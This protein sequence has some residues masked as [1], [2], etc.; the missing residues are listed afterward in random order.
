MKRGEELK[1][2]MVTQ[3]KRGEKIMIT[4]PEKRKLVIW[5]AQWR[6]EMRAKKG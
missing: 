6:W 5:A 3:E 1:V 4:R 2:H